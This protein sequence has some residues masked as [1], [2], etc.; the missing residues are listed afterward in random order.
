M[1]D[2]SSSNRGILM[3]FCLGQWGG[4]LSPSGPEK[5]KETINLLS[6]I[7]YCLSYD[8]IHNGVT[9]GRGSGAGQLAGAGQVVRGGL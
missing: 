1:L 5:T 3:H 2:V 8:I 7:G 9:W 6:R 4:A